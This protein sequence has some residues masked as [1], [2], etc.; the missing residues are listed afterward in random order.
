LPV[1]IS[2]RCGVG[3]WLDPAGSL[4]VGFGDVDALRSALREV[5][6]DSRIREAASKAAPAFREMLTWTRIAE[7]QLAFYQRIIGGDSPGLVSDR[8]VHA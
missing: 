2:D 7:E 5:L 8:V 6:F 3:E 4:V 1:V